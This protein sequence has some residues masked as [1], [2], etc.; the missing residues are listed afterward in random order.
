V[1]GGGSPRCAARVERSWGDALVAV[2]VESTT[3]ALV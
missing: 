2:V 1:G 3:A